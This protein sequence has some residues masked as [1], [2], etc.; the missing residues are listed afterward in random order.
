MQLPLLKTKVF[1]LSDKQL[2]VVSAHTGEINTVWAE[3]DNGRKV[4]LEV[5]TIWGEV[6]YREAK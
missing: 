6:K 2:Y 3:N 1:N 5:F 4:C